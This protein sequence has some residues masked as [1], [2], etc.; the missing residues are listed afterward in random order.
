MKSIKEFKKNDNN[1]IICNSQ[2]EF[3]AILRLFNPSDLKDSYFRLPQST[4]S[5]DGCYETD[6]DW[7]K[8][9][10]KFYCNASEILNQSYE[11]Y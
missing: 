4:I 11:I 1:F 2:E 9:N 7:M 6:I 3:S 10:Y 5:G 8:T